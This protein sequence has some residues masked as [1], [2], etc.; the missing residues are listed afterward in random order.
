MGSTSN[1]SIGK[2]Y[3]FAKEFKTKQI[4][5]FFFNVAVIGLDDSNKCMSC[6]PMLLLFFFLQH[7]FLCDSSLAEV[8][9]TLL[10]GKMSPFFFFF[11][12]LNQRRETK[13]CLKVPLES[14]KAS[15]ALQEVFFRGRGAFPFDSIKCRYTYMQWLELG[16]EG[17]QSRLHYLK[18]PK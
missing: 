11:F 13:V 9:L 4:F 6:C 3:K 5:F 7:M 2:Q 14:Y 15:R 12:L 18:S 10:K 8:P 16:W 1:Y 17:E